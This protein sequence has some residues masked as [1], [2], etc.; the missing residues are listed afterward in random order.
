MRLE[1]MLVGILI[2]GANLGFPIER[3]VCSVPR[4]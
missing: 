1:V 4:E 3:R 2:S